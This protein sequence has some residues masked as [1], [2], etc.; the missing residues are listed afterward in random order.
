MVKESEYYDILG[1]KID[2]SGAEIKKAYY[3]QVSL[4]VLS[5]DFH[6]YEFQ[7]DCQTPSISF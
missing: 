6:L 7:V 1:V 3:V 2:A 5:S 4:Y